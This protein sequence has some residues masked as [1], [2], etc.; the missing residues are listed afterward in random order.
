MSEGEGDNTQEQFQQF[1]KDN[2]IDFSSLKGTPEEEFVL[3]AKDK[4]AAAI[5]RS[6]LY[7][8]LTLPLETG[9]LPNDLPR[10]I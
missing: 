8:K 2:K 9:R 5:L 4:R 6:V 7:L 3:N 10:P 1:L